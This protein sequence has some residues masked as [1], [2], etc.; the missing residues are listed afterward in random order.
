MNGGM[1][2]TTVL[3]LE[4]PQGIFAHSRRLEVVNDGVEGYVE[5][6]ENLI[7]RTHLSVGI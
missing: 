2:A 4:K 7:S 5:S 1:L 6:N 3:Q